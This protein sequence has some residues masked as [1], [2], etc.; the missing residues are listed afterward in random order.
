MTIRQDAMGG[1]VND[2]A[3]DDRCADLGL[4]GRSTVEHNRGT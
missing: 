3:I 2:V 4:G 1:E